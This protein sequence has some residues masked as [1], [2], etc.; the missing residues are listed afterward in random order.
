[1]TRTIHTSLFL[2]LLFLASCG[3]EQKPEKEKKSLFIILDG[4][5]ADVLEM[6]D[7]P[8]LDDI[9]ETGS[10]TRAY[11]GGEIDGYSESPTV[12]AVGYNHLLTGVWS[13]KHNVYDNDIED[14]N[15]NYWNI[16]RLFK[17]NY[18][19]TKVAIYSSWMD[20]RTKLI[21]EGLPEAGSITIDISYDGFENDTLA[22]PHREDGS[23]VQDI[24]E[25]V[26]ELAS[27]SI[28]DDAPTLSWVYLW[29]PDSA[30]HYHGDGDIYYESLKVA[31]QQ[32]GSIWE[33]IQYR[34][35]N[36]NEDWQFMITTDHGRRLPDG[37]HHGE[38]TYRERTIWIVSNQP[39]KNSYFTE[40]KPAI[41]DLYPTV[42]RHL[43][44]EIPVPLER[45]L[46]GVPLIGDVSISHPTA[47][48]S[49]DQT[50]ITVGWK[51]WQNT[52]D[53]Q[54][55]VTK[56]N[57]FED[58]KEDEYHLLE[59]VSIQAEEAVVDVSEYS[60]DF[61]KVV[62]EGADNTLNRW[63]LVNE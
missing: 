4:I 45:E 10:Y 56:T 20:N 13:N 5:S 39:E 41:V 22:F 15:Y 55:Y 23:H 32:I 52:G 38:Q 33:A 21:G 57:E 50:E 59:E 24:D 29:Y 2:V 53:V 42:S 58:G 14:P 47:E 62:I 12:S 36:Y 49:A 51:A 48:L 27:E 19:E 7:T 35:E 16:F 44:L 46:D 37:R 61:Y 63:V 17:H 11:I 8:H 31:D 1:M 60:S 34:E 28:R 3:V 9:V 30:G 18:P 43:D 54:I 40:S 25:H 26:S 6:V